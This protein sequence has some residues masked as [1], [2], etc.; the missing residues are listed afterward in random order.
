MSKIT[1]AVP[2]CQ[3]GADQNLP[4]SQLTTTFADDS[5]LTMALLERLLHYADV[6]PV[7]GKGYRLKDKLKS[8]PV[9]PGETASPRKRTDLKYR[10]CGQFDLGGVGQF[11]TGVDIYYLEHSFLAEP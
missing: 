4:F 3:R 5:A 6:I 9:A 1:K 7:S 10:Q 11:S 8:G 2:T